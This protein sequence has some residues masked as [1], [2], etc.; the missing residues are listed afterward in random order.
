[1]IFVDNNWSRHARVARV[2]TGIAEFTISRLKLA[3]WL[4]LIA[5]N[6]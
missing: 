3:G 1:M 6:P 5:Q 2:C 4:T